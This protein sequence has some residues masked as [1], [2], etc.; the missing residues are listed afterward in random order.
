MKQ[1]LKKNCISIIT[2][3]HFDR[4][5]SIAIGP[6]GYPQVNLYEAEAEGEYV[7]FFEQAFEWEQISRWSQCIPSE[8][9]L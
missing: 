2:G 1:E 3:Q 5:N 7:R 4:F 8:R 9:F 6:W